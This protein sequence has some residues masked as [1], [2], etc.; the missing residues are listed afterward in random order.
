MQEPKQFDLTLLHRCSASTDTIAVRRHIS[1]LCYFLNA[2]RVTTEIPSRIMAALDQGKVMMWTA[3]HCSIRLLVV[4]A[5]AVSSLP[6]MA[7]VSKGS[8]SAVAPAAPAAP[9]AAPASSS[10]VSLGAIRW[11]NWSLDSPYGQVLADPGLRARAPYYTERLPNGNLGF[12]GNTERA[13]NADV[14]YAKSAG[15]DYFIFGYY[16]ESSSWGRDPS[17]AVALNRALGNFLRLPDKLGIKYALNFNL[18]FPPRDV[19]MVSDAISKAVAGP[20]YMRASDGSAP[21]F[22]LLGTMTPWIKGLGGEEGTKAALKDMRDRVK[23]ATGRDLYLV[24]LLFNLSETEPVAHRIGFDAASTYATA[25]G[26]NGKSLPYASCAALAQKAWQAEAQNGSGGFLPTVTLG[27]DYRPA[28]RDPQELKTRKPNPDWCQPATD[29]E[30]TRQIRAAISQAANNPRNDRFK[31]VVIYAWNESSEGGWI[32]PTL[33]EGVRRLKV[34][35]NA[36]GRRPTLPPFKLVW[37]TRI[38]PKACAVGSSSISTTTAGAGC[39]SASDS[40]TT[41]WPCPPGMQIAG[42]ELRQA[43]SEDGEKIPL[44]WQERLCTPQGKQQRSVN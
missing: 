10:K 40:M 36:A 42:E 19:P 3:R 44:I 39:K 8:P 30:W 2:C 15:L 21:V 28:L 37:P 32:Q 5:T 13:L 14:H 11:D 20:D 31:S 1:A 41:A 35:A 25:L 43:P 9:T 17:R 24:A 29:E 33:S 16:L 6:A 22:F 12:P 27:W 26:S 23:A 4:L 18:S 7:Q 34:I 38:D